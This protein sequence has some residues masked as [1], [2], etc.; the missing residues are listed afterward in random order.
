MPGEPYSFRGVDGQ[1]GPPPFNDI[2]TTRRD[3]GRRQVD[4]ARYRG[5]DDT[6]QIELRSEV[7]YANLKTGD[8]FI[9]C[10]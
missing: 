6:Q 7:N 2:T 9:A 1:R 3:D 10:E 8:A 4:D 5:A